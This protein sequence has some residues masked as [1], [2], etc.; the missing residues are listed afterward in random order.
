LREVHIAHERILNEKVAIWQ[1][2]LK[3]LEEIRAAGGGSAAQFTEAQ[4]TLSSAQTDLANVM[5]EHA[6]LRAEKAQSES[7]L[8]SLIA[9]REVLE[10]MSACATLKGDE[11]LHAFTVC[12]SAPGVIEQIGVTPGGLVDEN[13][14]VV[15]IVQP[16][17]VR[18]RARAMQSDL[19]RL[20]DGLA[21]RVVLSSSSGREQREALRGTLKI[22]LTASADERTV[23]LIVEPE[24][25]APW[26]R[27]G[28]SA[29]LEITL[30]GGTSELAIPQ[31]AVVRDG[32]TPIIFKRDPANPD[33]V[34][35]MEADLGISDGR[36][37]VIAS[38]VKEG[39]EIV[40]GGNY[41]LMLATSGSAPKGGHF[42]ADGTFHEGSH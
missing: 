24:T 18:F 23:D 6:H 33:K 25:G 17:R 19:A 27:A 20:S 34:I 37:V 32:L 40:V 26:A 41:Q 21:A 29:Q 12:A 7:Q 11:A 30:A 2:R 42:H 14:L 31:E 3:R 39:D 1:Q 5:E 8:R 4:A 22:G 36:W 35:R 16:D 38:G 10:R 28:V 13:G 9:R 15:S